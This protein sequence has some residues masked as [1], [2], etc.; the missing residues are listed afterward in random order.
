MHDETLREF[1]HLG[2]ERLADHLTAE[3]LLADCRQRNASEMASTMELTGQ[4][5]R[6]SSGVLESLF[7]QAPETL[8]QELMDFAP[9]VLK[10]WQWAEAFRQSLIWRE[11][12]AFTDRT[13]DWFN[14]SIERESDGTE[15]LEVVLTLASVPDHP[16]NAQ[17]L[18]RQLRK[19]S[20]PDRDRWWS[21]K[22]HFLYAERQSAPHRIIDWALSVKGTDRLD[23]D[24]VQLISSTLAWMFSSS[25]RFLRDRATKANLNL[26]TGRE[27]VAAELVRSFGEV[28]DLNIRE[29]VFAVAYGVAMRS[30]DAAR[31]RKLA[32]AVLATVF[33][34]VPVVPH[35]LLRDYARGVV[36]RSHRLVPFPDDAMRTVRPPYGSKW[37]R[38]P[39]ERVIKQ[40]K[41]SLDADG[42]DSHA[43]RRI[44]FS[45]LDDDFASYVI[46]TNSWS[47]DWLSI[48][49]DQPAWRSYEDM[50]RDFS[51]SLESGIKPIWDT[52]IEAE[53]RLAHLSAM[54]AW[55]AFR[56]SFSADE[57]TEDDLDVSLPAEKKSC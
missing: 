56:D 57:S 18:D 11:P 51:T 15:A 20:M 32:D 6:I 27:D 40:L 44:V 52:Y 24:V 22:L 33:T 25:N 43:A 17:F 26:L 53:G 13:L 14:K 46:G 35:L 54:K 41:D 47:T 1:V 2:Y 29:R 55:A 42:K 9:S 50:I 3:V 31:I 28:D 48:R 49:L 4:D 37:P 23:K 21:I 30:S 12:G 45:V 10:H 16:W 19:R 8:K 7:I 34:K 5:D 39:S 36:E 38:I